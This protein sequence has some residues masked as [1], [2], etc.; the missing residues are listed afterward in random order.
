MGL[1]Y[2]DSNGIIHSFSSA[3]ET[4]AVPTASKTQAGV[5]KIGNNLS[6]DEN[7]FLSADAQEI[8]LDAEPTAE[9]TNG[10]TSAGIKAYVDNAVDGLATTSDVEDALVG[11]ASEEYVTTA[12]EEI[13]V[14][15]DTVLKEGSLNAIQGRTV[16]NNLKKIDRYNEPVVTQPTDDKYIMSCNL[17]F[18]NSEE[19]SENMDFGTIAPTTNCGTELIWSYK[20]SGAGTLAEHFTDQ[21]FADTGYTLSQANS[22]LNYKGSAD[23]YERQAYYNMCAVLASAGYHFLST[24]LKKNQYYYPVRWYIK[25]SPEFDAGV[26][27]YTSSYNLGNHPLKLILGKGT[28][29]YYTEGSH[30]GGTIEY[31]YKV[32]KTGL[33]SFTGHTQVASHTTKIKNL[34]T[35][36][37]WNEEKGYYFSPLYDAHYEDSFSPYQKGTIINLY[38]P[39]YHSTKG[40]SFEETFATTYEEAN[41]HANAID[42]TTNTYWGGVNTLPTVSD[43]IVKDRWYCKLNQA[44]AA[45]S[46]SVTLNAGISLFDIQASKDGIEW[47]TIQIHSGATTDKKQITYTFSNLDKY[48]Y[49]GIAFY[50]KTAEG[51]AHLYEFAINHIEIVQFQ[52]PL[53]N[54]NSLGDKTI[55]GLIEA[56]HNYELVFNGESWD[57][58]NTEL[59]NYYTKHEVEQ[60]VKQAVTLENYY[61]KSQV[62]ELINNAISGTLGGNA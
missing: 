27:P 38:G 58:S 61:T 12:I 11:L 2:K 24:S 32:T 19:S 23:P 16:A 29:F 17:P 8:L 25:D 28:V 51:T 62:E 45:S 39:T 21:F 59:T 22:A 50:S 53:F 4:I 46:I 15:V 48:Q 9:S 20:S 41:P 44:C 31:V 36:N 35:K 1:M 30:V 60:I 56:N 54:I 13:K 40:Y 34:D 5:V 14:P 57:I 42:G 33:Y 26:H 7:G 47:T 37:L 10:V 49:Y 6:I 18:I 55:N 43:G 52:N 3:A